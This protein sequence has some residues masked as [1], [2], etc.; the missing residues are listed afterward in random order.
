MAQLMFYDKPVALNKEKHKNLKLTNNESGFAFANKT[1]SV[2]LS[3]MEFVRAA[4]EYPIIFIK[5]SQRILPVAL[6]GFRQDENLFVDAQ[7]KWEAKY[8]PAFVRRY[9]FVLAS[10]PDGDGDGGNEESNQLAVCI[11]ESFPGFNS[12]EGKPLFDEQGEK[13]E[14]LDSAI[15]FLQQYQSQYQRTDIFVKR[16][17]ELELLSEFTANAELKNGEKISVGGLMVVDEKKLLALDNDQSR[18]LFQSGEL[19]WIYAHLFS[20]SN[21]QELMSRMQP[22]QE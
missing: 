20:L 14:L 5:T 10:A 12:E 7:G 8:I 3:G 1:N 4:K 19:G 22:K 2:I 13:T 18:E 9:P 11:D 6:L 17:D 15:K 16:L 21:M